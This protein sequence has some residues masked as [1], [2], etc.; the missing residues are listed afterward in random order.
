MCIAHSQHR[1]SR[2]KITH[3][4]TGWRRKEKHQEFLTALL[5]SASHCACVRECVG[6]YMPAHNPTT[7]TDSLCV[8]VSVLGSLGG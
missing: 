4:L 3:L 8:P 6:A 5:P 1:G 7:R 2:G